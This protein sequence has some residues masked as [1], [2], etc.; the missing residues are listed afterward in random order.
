MVPRRGYKVINDY[1]QERGVTA[2]TVRLYNS[3]TKGKLP[4]LVNSVAK[5]G[6]SVMKH[7]FWSK[8]IHFAPG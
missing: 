8:F 6:Y 1:L 5:H 4:A 2:T 3:N 7:K